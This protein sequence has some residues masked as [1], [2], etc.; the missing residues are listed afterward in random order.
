MK[1]LGTLFLGVLLLVP[2]LSFAQTNASSTKQ[3]LIASLYTLLAQLEQEI[4]AIVAQQ[5]TLQTEQQTQTQQLQQITQNTSPTFGS[6]ENDGIVSGMSDTPTDQ[7]AIVVTVT[8]MMVAPFADPAALAWSQAHQADFPLGYYY[9]NAQVL[10]SNGDPISGSNGVLARPFT[11]ISM[12]Q[13]GVVTNASIDTMSGPLQPSMPAFHNF[14]FTPMA[15][16][17]YIFTFQSGVLS[18]TSTIVVSPLATSTQ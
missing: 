15:A 10:D 4:Q 3:A 2:S 18:A 5:Q 12:T 13:D 1:K 6:T 16:G 11:P 17:T 7:S 14:T 8:N 9:L